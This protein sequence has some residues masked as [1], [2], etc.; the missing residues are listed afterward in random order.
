VLYANYVEGEGGRGGD[1][2]MTEGEEGAGTER[3]R[4]GGEKEIDGF[5]KKK[6]AIDIHITD[7]SE[8]N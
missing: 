8:L 3:E 1:G 4:E 5:K 2:R 6:A 7:F